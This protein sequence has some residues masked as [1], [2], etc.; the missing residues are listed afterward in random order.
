MTRAKYVAAFDALEKIKEIAALDLGGEPD[1][2][3]V[4]EGQ[5]FRIDAPETRLDFGAV[6]ARAI[7]LGGKYSGYAAPPDINEMTRLSVAGLA[8][9]G[10]IGVARDNLE[11]IGTVPALAA[12][13][14]MIELDIETGKYEVLEFVSAA[15]CGTVLHPQ[16]LESQMKGGAVMGI[17]LAGLERHVYDAQNG[18]PANLSLGNAKPPTYLDATPEISTLAVGI[19]DPQNPVGAKGVGEP[20]EGC[21]AAALLSAIS[22][23]LRGHYF[24]RVP[25]TADMIVNAAAGRRQSHGPLSVNSF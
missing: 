12:G 9:T 6:A 24:N 20:L 11:K 8:G 22:D 25:V 7:E 19:A 17:G 3:D 18:F 23:A 21:A 10:L 2:Y 14:M 15:D 5:V 1:D 4:A 13:F 16:G